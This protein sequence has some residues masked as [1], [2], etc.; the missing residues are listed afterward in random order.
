MQTKV[1]HTKGESFLYRRR[2][3]L[4]TGSE[5]HSST[6]ADKSYS[7]KVRV[8]PLHMQTK[9]YS[10]EVSHSSTDADKSYSHEVRVIP[11]HMQKKVTHTK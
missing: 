5:S 1:T 10:H 9:S 3:K 7:H 2:Q 4:L 11:L 8:I 6:D